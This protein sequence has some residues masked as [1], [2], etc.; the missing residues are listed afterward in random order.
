MS[1]RNSFR[2]ASGSVGSRATDVFAN[3][4]FLAMTIPPNNLTE[5]P[6]G[7]LLQGQYIRP[8]L[9]QTTQ[10]LRLV[11]VPGERDFVAD[12]GGLLVQPGVRR[13]RQHLA[14]EEGLD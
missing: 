11:E 4:R 13:V 3:A 10:R 7:F 6:L 5:Q 12:L 2:R 8:N 9:L 14:A 1:S